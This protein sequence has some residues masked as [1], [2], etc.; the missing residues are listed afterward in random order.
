[1]KDAGEFCAAGTGRFWTTKYLLINR[2]GG[3]AGY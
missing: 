2:E 3:F 1:M